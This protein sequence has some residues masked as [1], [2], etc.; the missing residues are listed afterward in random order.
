[1]TETRQSVAGTPFSFTVYQDEENDQYFINVYM[2][3]SDEALFSLDRIDCMHPDIT[4]L[5]LVSVRR[6]SGVT[7]AQIGYVI[8][9]IQGFIEA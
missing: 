5:D 8:E 2:G 7:L 3:G 9:E 6:L 1:M 4:S